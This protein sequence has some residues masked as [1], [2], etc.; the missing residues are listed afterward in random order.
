M[1][2][3]VSL[4]AGSSRKE[5]VYRALEMIKDEIRARGKV[6]IKPNLSAFRNID[7]NTRPEAVEAVIDFLNERFEGLSITVG[8]SSGSAYLAGVR[9]KKLLERFGYFD[10]EKKYR[11]VRVIDLD[12]WK[13][14]R[15]M[16]VEMVYGHGDVRIMEHDFDYVV[17]VS[18]PKT[19]DFVIATLGIKNMMGTVHRH[20]RIHIHGL[21]GR[22]FLQGGTRIFPF[23][24]EFLWKPLHDLGRYLV[25][26]FGGYARS[27][28]L[29]NRNLA[30]L[31]KATKLDLVVLDA[32]TGMEGEGPLLGDTVKLGVAV[33]SADPLKADGVGAR[34]MGLQPG[35]IGY[36][37]YLQKDGYGDYSLEGLVGEGVEPYA[38]KFRMHS[39]HAEHAAWRTAETSLSFER[40]PRAAPRR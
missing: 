9:T 25:V 5:N 37:W 34:L 17:S 27:V 20:D 18:L 23:L 26:R 39:R 33:A 2:A 31:A 22:A 21:R 4:A 40:D 15:M 12:E 13:T 8:E 6:F 29:S 14:F 16:R 38:G 30:R 24:P 10:L 28:I 36:L 7:A 3:K 35:E 1:S 11:N 19:H 32:M